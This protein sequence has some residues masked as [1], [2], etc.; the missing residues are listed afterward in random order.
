MGK[1]EIS[2][3]I[4]ANISLKYLYFILR[5]DI[6]KGGIPRLRGD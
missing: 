1:G 5:K 2:R 6:K 3:G 4:R